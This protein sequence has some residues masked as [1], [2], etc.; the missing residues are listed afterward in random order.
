MQNTAELFAKKSLAKCV[1]CDFSSE[2]G[3][4]FHKKNEIGTNEHKFKRK[5]EEKT[6]MN[7]ISQR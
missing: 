4:Q 3:Q 1:Y 6:K 5:N 7:E 2:I